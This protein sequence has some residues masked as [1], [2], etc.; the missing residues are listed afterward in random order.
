MYGREKSEV[1][2][3]TNAVSAIMNTLSGS[4]KNCSSKSVIGPSLITLAV[5]IPAASSVSRLPAAL[6]SAAPRR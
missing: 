4:T 5:S 3:P 2:K 1:V 6:I